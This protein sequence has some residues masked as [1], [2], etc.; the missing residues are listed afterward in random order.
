MTPEH[1]LQTL[2]KRRG[3]EKND[4]SLDASLDKMEAMQKLRE[5]VA[6]ELGNGRWADRV[7]YLSK[8]CNVNESVS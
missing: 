3:L 1:I 8:E 5:C 7:L 4:T 6:W 2:R